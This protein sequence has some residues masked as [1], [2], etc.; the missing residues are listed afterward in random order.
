MNLNNSGKRWAFIEWHLPGINTIET[1]PD[2]FEQFR[3]TMGKGASLCSTLA[4]IFA[5][6]PQ[7]QLKMKNGEWRI[8]EREGEG[9]IFI[10]EKNSYASE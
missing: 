2:E 5:L 6:L 3:Q 1:G 9:Q 10:L 8:D 4:G 7:R